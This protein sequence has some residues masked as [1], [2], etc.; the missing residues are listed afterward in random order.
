MHDHARP[1]FKLLAQ[2]PDLPTHMEILF[3]K[4][5]NHANRFVQF[6]EGCDAKFLLCFLQLL[7]QFSIFLAQFTHRFISNPVDTWK[8]CA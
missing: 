3:F 2:T 5:F 4:Q 7:A 8:L 1:L 6:T